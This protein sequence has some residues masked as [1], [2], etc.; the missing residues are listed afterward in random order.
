MSV[1]FPTVSVR[2]S[3]VNIT[4]SL[5]SGFFFPGVKLHGRHVDQSHIASLVC[6]RVI[7]RGNFALHLLYVI[8]TNFHNE[9]VRKLSISLR[10][11][12]EF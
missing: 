8:E 10:P 12:S 6:S 2:S 7:A 11:I 1:K 9:W 4:S 3:V 5:G